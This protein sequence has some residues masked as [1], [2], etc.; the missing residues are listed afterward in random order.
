M[1]VSEAR[2]AA[3]IENGRKS[4]GPT[5]EAGKRRSRSC[6]I[7][8][9]LSGSGVVATEEDAAEIERRVE[10]FTADMNPRSAA[11]KELIRIIASASVRA[12]RATRH[13]SAAIARNVRNAAEAHDEERVER[14]RDQFESLA[15]DPRRYLRKLRKS[16]EGVELLLDAWDDLK[17]D[18]ALEPE[19]AWG[20][21]H[22]ERAANLTG[23]WARHARSSRFGVLTRAFR[24]DFAAL[25]DDEGGDLDEPVRRE[26]ARS[27][28]IEQIDAQ[29]ADLEAHYETLDFETI[30]LD[31]A[32]AGDR[33]LFDTSKEACLARRYASE[34]TRQF[35]KA[36][37]DFR[38]V[39][40]KGAVRP[41]PPPSPPRPAPSPSA[42][43]SL[44][45]FR[46]IAT[47]PASDPARVEPGSMTADAKV[48]PGRDGQPS[49]NLRPPQAP[50]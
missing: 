22:L 18:L 4:R 42:A 47:N 30:A 6:S 11:G 36:L 16:P 20:V 40:A 13:E 27:A 26:W 17:A 37:K 32:E 12:E 48:V 15:E 33:A 38:E 5:S 19:P 50:R 2:R 9:G 10:E 45:S 31:R 25:G 41:E 3:A 1:P 23:L 43:P 35:F 46:E 14:A 7:K 24:G 8:H 28:L 29:I 34:A 49:P 44:G 21:E 39:E